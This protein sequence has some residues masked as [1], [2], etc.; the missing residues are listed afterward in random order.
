MDDFVG[1]IPGSGIM[2]IKLKKNWPL[3][4][5]Y[6]AMRIELERILTLQVQ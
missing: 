3:V 1:P 4:S 6:P 2:K 5:N